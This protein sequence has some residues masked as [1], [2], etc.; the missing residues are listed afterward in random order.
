MLSPYIDHE[1]R[2]AERVALE[3]HLGIC[4]ACRSELE[5]FEKISEGLKQIYREFQ[6]PPDLVDRVMR[7][8]RDLEEGK[9]S[10]ALAGYFAAPSGSLLKLAAAAV[11][12]VG[13]GLGALR[14]GHALPA[15]TLWPAS[16]PGA[17]VAAEKG[18]P[19][20]QTAG[21]AEAGDTGASGE[22]GDGQ[23][24]GETPEALPSGG[25]PEPVKAEAV[26]SAGPSPSP[27]EAPANTAP[28]GALPE[29]P[30]A[31]TQL[32]S[33][34][35]ADA[36][37]PK[38]FLSKSRHVRVTWLKLEVDDLAAA[39]IGVA[40]AAAG[41]GAGGLS[42]LWV[43]QDKELILK[44]TLP[45]SAATEF[46]NRVAA[47]GTVLERRQETTDITGEFNNKLLEYQVLAA[48]EDE[49]SRA[50]ARALERHLEELDGETL[51]AGKEVVNIWLKLR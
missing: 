40:A 44:A 3:A 12:T 8:V 17:I 48:K 22:R 24:P 35:E 50:M 38:V 47:L 37:E 15:G 9:G 6:A 41:A 19:V 32:A 28:G 4:P 1:L 10:R 43:Y 51:E 42:E 30:Q 21:P 7:R 2:D 26:R 45:S 33:G 29:R 18:G 5:A 23:V 13:L 34:R 36:Y 31:A 14:Y 39:K 27:Q 46:L 20:T 16:P 25:S 49:E 11:L